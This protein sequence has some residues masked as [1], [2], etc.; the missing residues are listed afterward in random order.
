MM[1]KDGYRGNIDTMENASNNSENSLMKDSAY[2]SNNS[3]MKESSNNKPE[4][5]ASIFKK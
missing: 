4:N 2:N 3:L 1:K 5:K